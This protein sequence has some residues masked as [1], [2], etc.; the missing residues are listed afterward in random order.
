LHPS[1]KKGSHFVRAFF[2]PIYVSAILSIFSRM[3]SWTRLR[4]RD[5]PAKAAPIKIAI[6]QLA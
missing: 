1:Y 3:D 6:A 2:I 5:S 4:I